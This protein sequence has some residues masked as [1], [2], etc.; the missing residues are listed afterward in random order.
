MGIKLGLVGLGAFGSAFAPLFASHPLVDSVILC[1]AEADKVKK[2]A[3]DPTIAPKV[4]GKM[5]SLDE[6][7]KSDCDAVVIITQPWLHAPQCIQVL[8][9][10]K[11][12]YS[13]VPV[14]SLPDDNEMLDWCGKII[15]TVE[16]TGME[17]MLGE[18]T[19]YRPQ[20]MF[21][22]RMAQQGLF[23]DFVYAEAEYAHDVDNF[24]C[25]LRK[26]VTSRTTGKI[27][28]MREQILAPYYQR[29]CKSHPMAYPTH[30]VSGVV[31]VMRSKPVSVSAIGFANRNNDPHFAKY[32]FSNISA[33]FKMDN[34]C[35]LRVA[36][37]REISPNIGLDDEDF[38]IFGTRGSYSLNEWRNN[39]RVE[40]TPEPK[41]NE[42]TKLTAEEMR[43]PLPPEVSAAFS[44]ALSRKD[45]EVKDFLASGH[46]GSHPYLV[47]EFVS[48][49]AERRRPQVSAWDAA[50]YMAMGV[51]AHQSAQ[52]DGEI[53]KVVDFGKKWE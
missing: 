17:Y 27:G 6:V 35:A 13:A 1:D 21:C 49:V 15:E 9:A 42:L 31:E 22:R 16:R 32:D 4:A 7:C 5:L 28:Q 38:R 26:V 41:K 44:E 10:G 11:Y 19:I 46:G 53:V 18:T 20:T 43:D 30:S 37:M 47:H 14:I 36:E 40:P 51:A 24:Y 29:G 48:A 25:S 33:F 23:G 52:K 12:V 8:E 3:E 45:G 39:G 2:H 50:M 34:G